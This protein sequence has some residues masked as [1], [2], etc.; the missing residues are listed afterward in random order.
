MCG[1]KRCLTLFAFFCVT[2]GVILGPNITATLQKIGETSTT[3]TLDQE[4]K[5]LESVIAD[6][7]SDE[8]ASSV[9]RDEKAEVES[10][11]AVVTP[12][13]NLFVAEPVFHFGRREKQEQVHH[14]YH[15]ENRGSTPIEIGNVVRSNGAMT[16]SVVKKSILPGDTSD[17][18]VA[19]N[20]LTKTGDHKE[21]ITIFCN[22]TNYYDIC[23]ELHGTVYSRVKAE[24]SKLHATVAREV[25]SAEIDF[26]ISGIEGLEFDIVDTKMSD[27]SITASYS[28]LE[29]GVRYQAKVTVRAPESRGNFAGW[30]HFITDRRDTYTRIAFPITVDFEK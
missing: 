25:D 1:S 15:I 6:S 22:D 19:Y 28:P 2:I 18:R 29:E 10:D 14:T 21:K 16:V 12:L 4:G 17:V 13:R 9:D 20:V 24:P 30:V 23:L 3:E 26:V 11:A 5:L 7:P 8:S 27:K